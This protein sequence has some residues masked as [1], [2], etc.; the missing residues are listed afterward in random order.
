METPA[1]LNDQHAW[2]GQP[3]QHTP[4]DSSLIAN[5]QDQATLV[6][7]GQQNAQ[8]QPFPQTGV[9]ALSSEN[10]FHPVSHDPSSYAF[11]LPH[12]P[13]NPRFRAYNPLDMFQCPVPYRSPFSS[14]N[15]PTF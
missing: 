12:V 4:A 9:I 2:G 5:E 1:N 7:R 10:L 13:S 15:N 3:F 14:Y 8:V 6:A 11:K